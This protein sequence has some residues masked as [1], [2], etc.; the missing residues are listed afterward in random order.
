MSYEVFI[1]ERLKSK[2]YIH[3]NEAK[4]DILNALRAFSDL[5]PAEDV[6]V[7]S[8]GSRHNLLCLNGTIPVKYKGNVYNIPIQI[9][10]LT[11]HPFS[12]PL[13]YV[14]PAQ[15]MVIKP[16]KHVDNAGRVY[17]PYLSEWKGGKSD[18]YSMINMLC[19]IFGEFCPVY[20]KPPAGQPQPRPAY[21][22][23]HYNATGGPGY[24]THNIGMPQPGYPT[25]PPAYPQAQPNYTPYPNSS[26]PATSSYQTPATTATPPSRPPQPQ[27]GRQESVIQEETFRISLLQTAEDKLRRRVKEV[28]QMGQDE[29]ENLQKKKVDLESGNKQLQDMITKMNKEKANLESNISVLE[30]KTQELSTTLEKLE[31]DSENMNIDEA[32]VTTAPLYNQILKLFAEENAIEDTM[33]YLSEALRK[34]VIESDVF[35]RTVRDLS[36]KQFMLRATLQKARATAGLSSNPLG[37]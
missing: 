30:Q 8:D 18:S 10:L 7:R 37:R 34:G 14:R 19:M 29:L 5:H 36:R 9:W 3:K 15:N 20:S 25:Q 22:T 6:Y 23:P 2:Q 4:K 28:F 17:M 1:S 13:V 16:S 32:I 21:P 27:V 12:A 33:Y 35:L 11:S 31:Q 24:P 26:Y